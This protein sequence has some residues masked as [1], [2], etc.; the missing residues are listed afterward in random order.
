MLI[1]T[2]YLLTNGKS[3]IFGKTLT[4]AIDVEKR[5]AISESAQIVSFERLNRR[6]Y[7]CRLTH[8]CSGIITSK[9]SKGLT[10]MKIRDRGKI[11]WLGA[12]FAPEHRSMLREL[13]RDEMR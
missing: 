5:K 2:N 3:K 8:I 7:L 10:V 4:N 9:T 12:L 1:A 11:K 6:F 13:A